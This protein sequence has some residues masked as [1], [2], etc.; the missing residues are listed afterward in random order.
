[1]NLKLSGK[2]ST[3]PDCSV[4]LLFHYVILIYND[5]NI[6]TIAEAEWLSGFIWLRNLGILPL[7]IKKVTQIPCSTS[8][9][10]SPPFPPS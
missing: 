9:C 10:Q 1:M 3:S 4:I 2:D 8:A 5:T 7:S 6:V